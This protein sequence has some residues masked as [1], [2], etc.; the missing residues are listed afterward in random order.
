MSASKSFDDAARQAALEVANLVISKQHDYGQGNILNAPIKPELA[1]AVRLND[2]IQRLSHLVQ[3]GS[4]PNNESLQDTAMDI[5]GYG[6]VLNMLIGGTFT[7]PLMGKTKK[8]SGG[9][10]VEDET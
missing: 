10:I 8:L 6:L 1:L 9:V 4:S 5:M 2:K 3:S 7:L